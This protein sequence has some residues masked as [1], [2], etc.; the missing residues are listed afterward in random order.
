MTSVYCCTMLT[1]D[2]STRL[3][4]LRLLDLVNDKIIFLNKAAQKNLEIRDPKSCFIISNQALI[5]N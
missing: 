3:E 4:I 5:T 2:Y 1:E